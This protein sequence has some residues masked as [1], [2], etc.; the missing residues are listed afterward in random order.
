MKKYAKWRA[1]EIINACNN[2]EQPLATGEV[3]N[4]IYINFII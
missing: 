2:G 1:T 4:T 3:I